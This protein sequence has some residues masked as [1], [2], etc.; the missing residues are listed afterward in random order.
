MRIV[1]R[2]ARQR[3]TLL[4]TAAFPEI[5]NLIRHTILFGVPHVQHTKVIIQRL[6]RAVAKR[7]LA[8]TDGVRMA[9]RAKIHQSLA[10]EMLWVQDVCRSF[11]QGMSV[12]MLDMRFRWSVT[13]FARDTEE[14]RLEWTVMIERASL[15]IDPDGMTLKAL[16][17]QRAGPIA[18]AVRIKMSRT[19]TVL[20]M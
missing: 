11:L 19:P 8:K 5:P 6:T 12:V 15:E 1:A 7:R 16:R 4:V 14:L 17:C 3:F 13:S 10:A 20:G 2:D 18:C 9:L